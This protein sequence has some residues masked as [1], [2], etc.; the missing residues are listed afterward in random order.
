MTQI[1]PHSCVV[2]LQYDKVM[3]TISALE[4]GEVFVPHAWELQY[5]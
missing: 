5:L 2:E 3:E 1:I 4:D